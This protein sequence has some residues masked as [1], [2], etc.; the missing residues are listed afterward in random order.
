MTQ[1]TGTATPRVVVL[2]F[3][4]RL[5]ERVSTYVD[6][7]V[8]AG[9]QVDL[10][11]PE[12]RTLEQAKVDP[13]VRIHTVTGK[14]TELLVRRL[15][16]L[17]LYRVPGGVLKRANRLGERAGWRPLVSLVVVT[18]RGH[19]RV[20]NAVH[21]RMFLPFYRNARAYLLARHAGRSL[22]DV[23][24]GT[25]DRIIAA[26]IQAVALGWRL[27]RQH[28]KVIATTTLDATVYARPDDV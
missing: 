3:N 6:A 21:Q 16:R 14:E 15:E 19:R 26:D 9:V 8:A 5:A 10:V 24:F 23:D 4:H 25:A 27:A 12:G 13:R 2:A 20:A 22:S 1:D 28:P 18:Q 17:V 11:V 7:V